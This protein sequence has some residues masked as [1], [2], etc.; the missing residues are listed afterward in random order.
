[1]NGSFLGGKLV[2]SRTGPEKIADDWRDRVNR[3]DEE[4]AR[5]RYDAMAVRNIKPM[6]KRTV[7]THWTIATMQRVGEIHKRS[8]KVPPTRYPQPMMRVTSRPH[9]AES[10]HSACGAP[11][12]IVRLRGRKGLQAARSK[13]NIGAV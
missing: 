12:L 5:P 7:A 13:P 10:C 9:G 2:E 1:M 6:M 3:S 4:E 8:A 11:F